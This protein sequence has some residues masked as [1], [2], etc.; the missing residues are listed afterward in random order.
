[1]SLLFRPRGRSIPSTIHE[2]ATALQ[3]ITMNWGG[4]LEATRE[5]KNKQ[6]KADASAVKAL[7]MT[8][9]GRK[10]GDVFVTP[11]KPQKSQVL[12]KRQGRYVLRDMDAFGTGGDLANGREVGPMLS[13]CRVRKGQHDAVWEQ[14]IQSKRKK[15]EKNRNNH[16]LSTKANEYRFCWNNT[17]RECREEY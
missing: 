16:R 12:K 14:A 10:G 17:Q 8:V 9:E 4:G 5:G 6:S 3:D 13:A 7:K 1:M 11:Y 15:I 2:A